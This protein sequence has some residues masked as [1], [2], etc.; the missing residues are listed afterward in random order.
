MSLEN[1]GWLQGGLVGGVC[2]AIVALLVSRWLTPAAVPVSTTPAPPSATEIVVDEAA[3]QFVERCL[4]H[5]KNHRLEEFAQ[6][7]RQSRAVVRDEDL[8]KFLE[9]LRA[10][11]ELSLRS[12]GQPLGEYELLRVTAPSPSV[13]RF[14]YLER[15]ERG[16]VWWMF[17]LYRTPERWQMAWVDWGGNLA[18]LFAGLS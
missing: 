1:K 15:F 3:K 17:V 12:F 5:I 2:G 14:I 8:K 4:S 7:A 11:R 10:D 6:E 13:V 18:L 16:A 9:R